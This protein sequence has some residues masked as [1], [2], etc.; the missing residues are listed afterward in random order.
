MVETQILQSSFAPHL[1][2]APVPNFPF[3]D[4]SKWRKTGCPFAIEIGCGV[5][6]HAILWAKYNPGVQ[7]LAIERTK[8]KFEKFNRRLF[9]HRQFASLIFAARADANWL[10]PHLLVPNSVDEY[11][12][13][14]PNPEPKRRN[15]RIAFSNL[16]EIVVSTLKSGGK[17]II[18]TNI[19]NYANEVRHWLPFKYPLILECERHLCRDDLVAGRHQFRSH[20]EKKYLER[21]DLCFDFEFRKT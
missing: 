14:Y 8:E 5:G 21:E 2:R 9:H 16:I 7:L 6:Y 10:L 1:T 18:A 17:L 15:H 4:F 12:W 3:S 19:A 13:L 20:F 11:F